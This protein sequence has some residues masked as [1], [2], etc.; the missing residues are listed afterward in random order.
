MYIHMHICSHFY[1]SRGV[2]KEIQQDI[3]L[4]RVVVIY[5]YIYIWG[6]IYIHIHIYNH[7]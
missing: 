2:H 6:D 4:Y 7:F 5:T 1:I 3:D